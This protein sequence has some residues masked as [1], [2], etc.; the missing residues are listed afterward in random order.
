MIGKKIR[1]NRIV[2]QDT[3]HT[4]IVPMDH[5]IFSGYLCGFK[6]M[7]GQIKKIIKGG[8]NAII[9][10]KGMFNTLENDMVSIDGNYI[11]HMS[12]SVNISKTANIK[13][14]VSSLECALK[15]GAVGVSVQVNIGTEEDDKMLTDLGMISDQCFS[16][17]MPLL[18]MMY[19][20]NPEMDQYDADNI[21][22]L[23][24]IAEDLGADIV[25]INCPSDPNA[26]QNICD[27]S[28]IPVVISGGPKINIAEI[29]N[30][31]SFAISKGI[32]G[33]A[34]GRNIFDSE[35][36][37]LMTM[38]ISNLIHNKFTLNQALS[39]VNADLG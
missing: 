7:P 27:Y 26:L 35:N 3:N 19:I 23:V 14:I 31:I 13:N 38:A 5:G 18:A 20:N 1:L 12:A 9:L 37:E 15:S 28:N 33:V 2:N 16:W 39:L 25:K 8:A 24:K 11:M 17:G 36:P 4:C 34:I 32:S 22:H 10:N 21:A 29:L 6:N 30:L